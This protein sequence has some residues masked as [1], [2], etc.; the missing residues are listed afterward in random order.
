MRLSIPLFANLLSILQLVESSTLD[1]IYNYKNRTAYIHLQEENVLIPLSF[2]SKYSSGDKVSSIIEPPSEDCKILSANSNLYAFYPDNNNLTTVSIF[3]ETSNSWDDLKMQSDL[4]YLEKSVYINTFDDSGSLFIY[5]GYNETSQEASGRLVEPDVNSMNL[6]NTTT[7][8]QPT[9]FY[10][11]SSVL[12][13]YNT[14][15]FIGGKASSGF[16]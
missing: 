9:A 14:Q 10:D 13:N 8:I 3:N 4:E 5:G 1:T 2:N 6:T 7:S 11:A 12:I 15:V 16:C